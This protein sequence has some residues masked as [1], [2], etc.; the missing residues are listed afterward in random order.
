MNTVYLARF[1]GR[2]LDV[3]DPSALPD[4][5]AL[6]VLSAI[7]SGLADFYRLAPENFRK[8]TFSTT[9][10]KP[11]SVNVEF[12]VQYSN[13]VLSPTF[14]TRQIGCTLRVS[15]YPMDCRI[16]GPAIVLDDFL[17]TTLTGSGTVFGD[18]VVINGQIER[19]TSDVR[20]RGLTLQEWKV[21]DQ[22]AFP[23]CDPQA[24]GVPD[25]YKIEPLGICQGGDTAALLRVYPIPLVDY[26]VR[27]EAL[28]S[29]ARKVTFAMLTD[30]ED[31]PVADAYA[32][33]ILAPICAQHLL[34]SPFWNGPKLSTVEDARAAFEKLNLLPREMATAHNTVGTREG[35]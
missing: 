3:A 34:T 2:N 27:F 12:E 16:A 28:L 32:E 31:L 7:N 26:I 22:K 8:T 1:L 6:D 20:V 21:L 9:L 29:A 17:G 25:R 30:A 10:R 5:A 11:E 33:S 35:F 23:Q 14:S 13:V 4:D 18:A 15:G 19:L 24:S